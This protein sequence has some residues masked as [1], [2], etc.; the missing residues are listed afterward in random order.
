[1]VILSVAVPGPW[2]TDLSYTHTSCL[3]AGAR[4]RVP[5]GTSSRVGL[6][7]SAVDDRPHGCPE[8]L[9]EIIDAIDNSA[10]LPDELWRTLCWFAKTWFIGK[11]MAAKVL[12]PASFLEGGPLEEITHKPGT[13]SSSVKYVYEPRDSNRMGIYRDILASSKNSV[14]ALFPELSAAKRFWDLLPED[15]KEEGVLWPDLSKRKQWDFW[16][17]S[18]RGE[19]RF[20][21]GC[22]TASFIP[23]SG[24][25]TIIVDEENSGAWKTQKHPEFHHRTILAARAGFASADLILGGRMPSAKAFLQGGKDQDR[26]RIRDRLVFVDM[27]DSSSYSFDGIKDRL[28]ISR[29]LVRETKESLEK[30]KWVFW[31]LDRKGYAGEIFCEDCGSPVRCRNCAGV[32]RWEGKTELLRCLD[33]GK[34]E[35]LPEKCPSCGGPFL[36]GQRPGLE[37]LEEHARNFFRS[38]EVVLFSEDGSKMPSGQSIIKKQ[39]GAGIILGTRKILSLTDD[40]SPGAIGWID[41]DAEARLEEYD[42][43]ARAFSLMWES[44]WRGLRPESRKVVIQ[45]RRPDK[46]WQQAL[47][48]GWGYFWERELKERKEWELPPFLPMLRIDLPAFKRKRLAEALELRGFEYWE[49]EDR[50]DRIWVRTK[51]FDSL[52]NLLSEYF[53]IKNTRTGIPRVTIK[54]D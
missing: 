12:L 13:G 30:G 18:R 51:K 8:D 39:T 53:D 42:A 32:M 25:S 29:P 44:A 38:T 7:V 5:L 52:R 11:G 19:I 37:A 16:K 2:W 23:I 1:M 24:L 22:Q 47:G 26:I 17:R 49:S 4:V 20:A 46:S 48:I 45:S 36:Q 54:L 27:R 6:A 50:S 3:P 35:P 14:L 43:K 9:K 28:P 33:C 40:L 31:I 21:V 41:A 15:L 34:M 10:P